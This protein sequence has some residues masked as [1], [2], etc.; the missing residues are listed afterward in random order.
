VK[1]IICGAHGALHIRSLTPAWESCECGNVVARWEDAVA[2]TMAAAARQPHLVR[3]LGLNNS[4]LTSALTS[5]GQMWEEYRNWHEVA[6]SAPGYIFDKSRA[7]CW[8]V[9]FRI[10]TTSDSRWVAGEEYDEA[11]LA[12]GRVP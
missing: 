2:G 1:A 7:A 6:T 11:F 8:A 4:L 5:R 12:A 3:G 10:G 9:V